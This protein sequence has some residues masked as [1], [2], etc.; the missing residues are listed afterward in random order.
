MVQP[1]RFCCVSLAADTKQWAVFFPYFTKQMTLNCSQPQ[2]EFPLYL[3][4]AVL[5]IVITDKIKGQSVPL[6]Y[7]FLSIYLLPN[8]WWNTRLGML[9][10]CFHSG[11]VNTE[12]HTSSAKNKPFHSQPSPPV[13]KQEG[14]RQGKHMA[15]FGSVGSVC[16]VGCL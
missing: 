3:M 14:E 5:I 8:H 12:N 15:A 10:Y 11:T 1:L 6:H 4:L 7:F 2:W 9:S 13:K 16:K